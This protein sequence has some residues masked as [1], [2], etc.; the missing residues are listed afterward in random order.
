MGHPLG[1]VVTSPEVSSQLVLSCRKGTGVCHL[2]G[3]DFLFSGVHISL[4]LQK[5]G[6][7]GRRC[8]C[9]LQWCSGTENLVGSLWF[10]PPPS[11]GEGATGT[12]VPGAG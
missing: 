9:G 10:S 4:G 8:V 5:A 2:R 11:W 12:R 1:S 3:W 6:E 7:G